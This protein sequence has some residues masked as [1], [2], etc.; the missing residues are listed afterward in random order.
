MA[1][2]ED[3][4]KATKMPPN[5]QYAYMSLWCMMASPLFYSGDM[6]RLDAFTLN[7]LCNP[8]VI[9]IDQDPLGECAQVIERKN[10]TFY[11]GEKFG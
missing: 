4:A 9:A 3:E 11:Y 6:T 7:V 5:M 10:S 2:G 1:N 8:E